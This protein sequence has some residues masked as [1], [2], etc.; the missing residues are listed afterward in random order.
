MKK[1]IELNSC[2]ACGCVDLI[3]TLDLGD[4]P[5]ANS[6]TKSNTEN[7]DEFPLNINRCSDCNHIQLSVAVN[8]DLMFKDYLYVSG[9][10]KTM[11]EYFDWFASFTKEYHEMLFGDTLQLHAL[12]I[13][14]NDGSMLDKYKTLNIDTQ[15]IDPAENLFSESSK[16]HNIICGY[17][18][19][20]TIHKLCLF[21]SNLP[22]IIVAQ[23]VFAHNYDP[24]SFM[25]NIKQILNDKSLFFVQTSQ[26]NMIL[27]NEYD[28]I[29]HE[30]ISFYNIKSMQKLCERAGLKLIDVVKSTIHGSSYIFIISNGSLSRDKNVENLIKME[31][32]YGLYSD[33]T[34]TNYSSICE[35]SKL[36]IYENINKFKLD[37]FKII[38][39]GAAAKGN[40]LLNFTGIKLDYV[41]DDNPLKWNH[42]TPG[43]KVE[44]VS[45][46]IL[47]T[48]SETDKILYI[49]L[50]WNFFK[51][52]K[53]NIKLKRNNINDKFLMY[54]PDIKIF[55]E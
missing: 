23:N 21:N 36:K 41:I 2:L 51:E 46:D 11:L 7:L 6:Y 5:L 9:T 12:D 43:S 30:H 15:G 19:S 13:G 1:Y 35:N 45:K 34:Y 39:Y 42:F 24:L 49:P 48:F 28:T 4:Q 27:N 26:A 55:S 29:Y 22:S 25:L 40:T 37:G 31:D 14:C 20:T 18:D 32:L 53:N 38:G 50:A 10:S 16:K 17:F 47:D 33:S 54:F 8:P 3:P 52:I 44:I